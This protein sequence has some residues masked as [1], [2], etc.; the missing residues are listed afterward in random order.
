MNTSHEQ[1]TSNIYA[2][3]V[4]TS[5]RRWSAPHQA[6]T[7][8]SPKAWPM[9]RGHANARLPRRPAKSCGGGLAGW[10]CHIDDTAV[11]FVDYC[12]MLTWVLCV[13][14]SGCSVCCA[15]GALCAVQTRAVTE[16]SS[17]RALGP[18]ACNRAP[19]TPHSTPH[20]RT[21]QGAPVAS[22]DSL[23]MTAVEHRAHT[24]GSSS[25]SSNNTRIPSVVC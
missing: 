22:I 13:L 7:R 16:K 17:S 2:T 20:A 19:R 12:S 3:Y 8:T 21:A 23:R 14:C 10:R 5:H 6:T 18:G 25:N 4:R 24:R 1:Q 11:R 9:R 15:V